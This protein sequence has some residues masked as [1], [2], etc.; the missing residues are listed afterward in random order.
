MTGSRTRLFGLAIAALCALA[1]AVARSGQPLDAGLPAAIELKDMTWV[2][3]RT[4]IREGY[5][6]V[7]VPTGGIEQNGPHMI[8]GKHDYIV[9]WAANR[10]ALGAGR[11]LVAPVVSYV[12][13]GGYEPA[14]GHMRFPGT[15]GVSEAAFAGV[16]EGIARSLKT[17]GFTLIC[18][19]G[20]H[21][22]SQRVQSEAAA[23]LS[24]EWERDGVRVVHLNA[25]YDD[26]EQVKRLEA[27]GETASTIGQHAAIIDTSE[28]MAAHPAGVDL[29]RL[30]K[31]GFFTEATGSSGDPA[32]SSAQR[33]RGLIMMRV[34]AAIAQ[35]NALRSR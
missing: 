27:E 22:G 24:K 18:F 26:A 31:S 33:G 20:D 30:P 2:E 23:R 11:T 5:K 21:G 12:P 10:I 4:A 6:T 8:L 14:T 16:L 17:H 29:S 34:E 32:R 9:G 15:L 35:I 3:V 25:Y 13:E 28:L 19:M 7:L 1:A